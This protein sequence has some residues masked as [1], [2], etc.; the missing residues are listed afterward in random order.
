MP[1]ELSAPS[2][3]SYGNSISQVSTLAIFINWLFNLIMASSL[4]YIWGMINTIQIF[5]HLA[6]L[7]VEIPIESKKILGILIQLTSMQIISSNYLF[8]LVF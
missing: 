5:T 8:S 7:N 1:K 2:K 6:L 4:Q 3:Y